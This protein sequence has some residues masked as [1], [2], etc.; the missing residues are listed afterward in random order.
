MQGHTQW[1]DVIW[2]F[3][4]ALLSWLPSSCFHQKQEMLQ[5][6]LCCCFSRSRW[7]GNDTVLPVNVPLSVHSWC[8]AGA[9]GVKGLSSQAGVKFS[10]VFPTCSFLVILSVGR[11]SPC[12]LPPLLHPHLSLCAG[13]LG[14]GEGPGALGLLHLCCSQSQKKEVKGEAAA[15]QLRR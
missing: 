5:F 2:P 11:F 12:C 4:T 14:L 8:F 1:G 15:Q 3:I 13:F 6:M 9:G 10:F 7:H